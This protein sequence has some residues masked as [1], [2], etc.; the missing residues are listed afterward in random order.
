MLKKILLTI[1]LSSLVSCGFRIIY[2]ERNDVVSYA[3][4][5]AEI[6][7]KKDRTRL[8]QELK[9][10]LYDILNPDYIKAEAK[11][12][13]I[14]TVNNGTSSSLTTS[15]GSSGRNR[16]V[17]NA[18]YELKSLKTGDTISKGSTSVNDSYDVTTNRYGTYV[19][20]D[21]VQS[22]LTKIAA[23]NIRNSLVNDMIEAIR[24]CED[25]TKIKEDEGFVCP[26][27]DYTNTTTEKTN[28]KK[29]SGDKGLKHR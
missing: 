6:R 4:R 26:L 25:K 14:L 12:F 9:N 22:N 15:T 24:K 17:L 18:T 23:Q 21:Y 29:L 28:S 7:I 3:Q 8:S 5:L 13:L 19:A 10:N 27:E 20:G 2:E 11:Y 1:I 16:V